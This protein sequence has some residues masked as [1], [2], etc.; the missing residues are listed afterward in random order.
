MILMGKKGEITK[1]HNGAMQETGWQATGTNIAK[2]NLDF[3]R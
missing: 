1:K 3:S 2:A